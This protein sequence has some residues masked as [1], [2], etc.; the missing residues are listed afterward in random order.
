MVVNP[1]V[2]NAINHALCGV[3]CSLQIVSVAAVKLIPR[4]VHSY[5]SDTTNRQNQTWT[6]QLP[7]MTI[8]PSA[9]FYTKDHLSSYYLKTIAFGTELV[10]FN[11]L[12]VLFE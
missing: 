6:Y 2:E 5:Y 7:N 12:V 4:I 1:L 9:I 8:A 10:A 11:G 3:W